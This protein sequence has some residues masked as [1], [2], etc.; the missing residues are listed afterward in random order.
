[1]PEVEFQPTTF[2]FHGTNNLYAELI[3]K[4]II[5]TKRKGAGVDFGPGF[6]LTRNI[7]QAKEFTKIRTK[8]NNW[9]VPQKNGSSQFSMG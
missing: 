1:M 9:A 6:Y 2:F 7:E 5:I 3:S 8:T 4:E